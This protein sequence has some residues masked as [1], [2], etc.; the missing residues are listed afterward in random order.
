MRTLAAAGVFAAALGLAA[1]TSAQAITHPT[2]APDRTAAGTEWYA[3]R[4]PIFV[5]GNYYYPTGPTRFFEGNTMAPCAFFDGVPVYQDT[6][7]EPYSVIYVPVSR[8]VVR[9]YELRRAGVLAGT[10]GSRAP[11]FPVQHEAEA[12][13]ITPEE[14]LVDRW[15]SSPALAAP[16]DEAVLSYP[17]GTGGYV[18]PREE[19][20]ESP[21]P[22]MSLVPGGVHTAL[23]PQYESA[24]WVEYSG[25]RGFASGPAALL[26]AREYET[27]D[28]FEGRPVYRRRGDSSATIY[29]PMTEGVVVPFEKR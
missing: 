13:P 5:L 24:I 7:L 21:A 6:T 11:S 1:V 18:R 2:P 9:P 15:T 14:A 22:P 26:N 19:E 29:L 10:T 16:T 3:S 28:T 4:E 12:A 23:R 27:V 17:V 25:A 8:G 20:P